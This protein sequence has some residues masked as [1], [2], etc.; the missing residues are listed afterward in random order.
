MVYS[1]ITGI[2]VGKIDYSETKNKAY[3]GSNT[4]I[5]VDTAYN[6]AKVQLYVKSKNEF[7]NVRIPYK[8]T[9]GASIKNPDGNV[10]NY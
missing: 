5:G 1:G 3:C 7:K 8:V 6:V 2:R 10:E 4:F 9:R